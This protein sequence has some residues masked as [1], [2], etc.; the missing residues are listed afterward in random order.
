MVS[1]VVTGFLDRVVRTG[2][3]EK[4][5]APS[6]LIRTASLRESTST[7]AVPLAGRADPVGWAGPVAQ[8]GLVDSSPIIL[9]GDM[10]MEAQ[11]AMVPLAAMEAGAGVAAT[12]EVSRFSLEK[13]PLVHLR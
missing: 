6:S 9:P 8:V 1:A 4:T 13:L 3:P 2:K 11:A 12:R 10:A 5:V 7:L